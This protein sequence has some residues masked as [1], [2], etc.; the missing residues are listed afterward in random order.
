MKEEEV[1]SIL[2]YYECTD[3]RSLTKKMQNIEPF[4]T[5]QAH[6]IEVEGDYKV[7]SFI[8]YFT[9]DIPY[10]LM[11]I[12]AFAEKTNTPTPKIDEVLEWAQKVMGK[13]YIVNGKLIGRD[14]KEGYNCHNIEI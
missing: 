7:D 10:G 2:E 5:V 13:E 9:E 4:K 14:A 11:L 8:R 6:M 1:P 12:K 3:A